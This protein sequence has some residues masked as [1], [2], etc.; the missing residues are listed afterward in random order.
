MDEAALK[1][2]SYQNQADV[3]VVRP[4]CSQPFSRYILYTIPDLNYTSA[5]L[6]PDFNDIFD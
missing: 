4:T 6:S 2:I 3:N 1:W 5:N